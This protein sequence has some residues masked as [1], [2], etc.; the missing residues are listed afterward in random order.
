MKLDEI[1]HKGTYHS[2]IDLEIDIEPFKDINELR[3]YIKLNKARIYRQKNSEYYKNYMRERYRKIK[4][5]PEE[6]YR[7]YKVKSKSPPTNTP[8]ILEIQSQFF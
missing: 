7:K 2:I 5:L 4:E 8:C 1:K 3:D 6:K